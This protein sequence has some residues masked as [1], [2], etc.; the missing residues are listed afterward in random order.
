[1]YPRRRSSPAA[2]WSA[3]RV[4]EGPRCPRASLLEQKSSSRDVAPGGAPARPR[5]QRAKNGSKF[6]ADRGHCL[7]KRLEEVLR[8]DVKLL[9]LAECSGDSDMGGRRPACDPLAGDVLDSADDPES[10]AGAFLDAAS[11]RPQVADFAPGQLDTVF[12][13][14]QITDTDRAGELRVS[15]DPF[16]VVRMRQREDGL[17]A[18]H[19]LA[20]LE[21]VEPIKVV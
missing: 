16:V 19:D 7:T 3:M 14:R 2:A 5:D 18:E 8:A 20:R 6:A 10:A 4:R 9:P 12:E 13:W 11:G 1:M 15:H 17:G 21:S